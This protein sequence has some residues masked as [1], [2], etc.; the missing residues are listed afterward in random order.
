[1]TK[2]RI[3]DQREAGILMAMAA[4][5]FG[6][7]LRL[8]IPAIAGFPVNDG[9][10]FYVMIRAIQQHGFQ[11]PPYVHYNGIEI[12]F[13][14]PP[15]GFYLGAALSNVFHVDATQILRWAPATILILS[16][17]AFYFLSRT[18]LGTEFKAGLA[19]LVF[20]FTPRAITW[21]IMG[22]G[23]TRS[24]GLFLMLLAL[25]SIYRLFINRDRRDLLLATLLSTLLSLSHPEA[26][27]QTIGLALLFW[28]FAGRDRQRT[29]L[30]LYVALGTVAGSGLWWIPT[31]FRLGPE[32]FL[33]AAQT[34]AHSTL[35]ILYPFFALITDEPLMTFI[36]VLGLLGFV[37]CLAKKQ[38]LLPAA[39]ILPFIVEPRSAAT[40]AMIPLALLASVSLA[41]VI[42]PALAGMQHVSPDQPLV[43]RA[44]Q[45]SLLFIL[46]YLFGSGFY[47]GGRL[48]ATTLMPSDR[49]A[50]EWVRA[51]TQTDS[52]FLILTGVEEVFCDSV[53]EWFPALTGRTS[54][55]T[56]QGNEW[57]TGSYRTASATQAIT[58][59]C[60]LEGEP[61]GCVED[62]AH[63]AGLNFNYV[64]VSK[65]VKVQNLCRV[66]ATLPGHEGLVA[67]L[68]SNPGYKPVFESELVAIFARQR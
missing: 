39:Y 26:A 66:T 58:Q 52:R 16:I 65:K 7:W 3:P 4:T 57:L 27:L 1:M 48:A 41:D 62:E 64:Y 53:S 35:G 22:G 42:F 14:Y 49:A 59:H 6:A 19:T 2:L 17:P 36:A 54:V 28:L 38:Y 12:P 40:Y 5:I 33:A 13:A 20:A 50:F 67:A 63:K 8:F 29:L 32:P 11:L 18:L 56:I 46:A 31:L 45:G 30:A 9:G 21:Q 43:S 47:Y 34:G 23:L 25:T 10:L 51:N 55:T 68:K 37:I 60:L 15:L 61:L 44:V 24:L